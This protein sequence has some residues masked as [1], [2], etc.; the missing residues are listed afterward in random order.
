MYPTVEHA[1]K[2]VKAGVFAAQ[3]YGDFS[4]MGKGGSSL[5]PYHKFEDKLPPLVKEMVQRKKDEIL[6]GTFRVDVDEATPVSD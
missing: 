2:L 6:E 1:V 3:D 5:A 4:R